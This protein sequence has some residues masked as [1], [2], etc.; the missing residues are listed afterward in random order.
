MLRRSVTALASLAM[1]LALCAEVSAQVRTS[2]RPRAGQVGSSETQKGN[3]SPGSTKNEGK[4]AVDSE[5]PATPP[6]DTESK[7]KDQTP[8][9]DPKTTALAT[10]GGG[11]FWCLEAVFE[12]IPGVKSVVSGYAGGAVPNPTYQQVCT[13]MTG[14]AEVVQIEYFPAVVSFDTLLD[15]FWECH[16]PTT[17]NRQGPDVGT[18]YRSIILYHDLT[19][20]EAAEK[21]YE[22]LTKARKFRS[23][24]VTQL[25]P[26]IT[27]YLAEPYHQDYFRKHPR[28]PYCRVQIPP[29]LKKLKLK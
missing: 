27:F 2:P 5:T 18:Q 24:I 26:L 29:K 15:Y 7:D 3:D 10:F 13:G 22:Q 25:V 1:A 9:V 28:D 17:L 14:H 4:P 21:S 16:D 11:C 8:A 20:K 19:Q 12:R 6:G 23:P